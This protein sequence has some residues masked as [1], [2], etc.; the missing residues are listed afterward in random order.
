MQK[1]HFYSIWQDARKHEFVIAHMKLHW[2]KLKYT[3]KKGKKKKLF[4]WLFSLSLHLFCHLQKLGLA[5]QVSR[6]SDIMNIQVDECCTEDW[7]RLSLLLLQACHMYTN[8]HSRTHVQLHAQK[9]HIFCRSADIIAFG[10]W[11]STL[12]H[13]LKQSLCIA[14][15]Q[16]QWHH[17]I[18][19]ARSPPPSLPPSWLIFAHIEVSVKGQRFATALAQQNTLNASI[20]THK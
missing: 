7:R 4:S 19:S 6:E 14:T 2:C 10:L 17:C 1:R 18:V 11:L 9:P 13:H 15:P 3:K 8:I 12:H 16:G 5:K 20:P